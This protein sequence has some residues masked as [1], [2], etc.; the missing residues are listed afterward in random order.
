MVKNIGVVLFICF[1]TACS[2]PKESAISNSSQ[3]NSLINKWHQAAAVADEEVFFNCME[4][5]AIYL[6]TDA[7]EKWTKKE[8]QEWSKE[9]F[10]RD[11]AWAFT[12]L[13]RSIYFNNDSSLCWFDEK[14]DT[15]MGE[16]RGTGVLKN[17]TSGWRISHYNL[18]VTIPNELIKQFITLTKKDPALNN[19]E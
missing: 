17:S 4:D 18:S 15:W 11:T 3:V 2:K 13:E 7:S 1:F 19:A 14:L 9:I 6:G 16:C 5:D 10:K 8:L 12:P